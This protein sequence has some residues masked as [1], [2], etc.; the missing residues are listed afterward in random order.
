M[1]K[2]IKLL[3]LGAL[4]SFSIKAQSDTAFIQQQIRLTLDS[5]STSFFN[6]DWAGFTEF[7]YPDLI[8]MIGTK[9]EFTS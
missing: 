6:K 4:F 1:Y 2:K 3:T 9:E 7:M 8:K 5:V